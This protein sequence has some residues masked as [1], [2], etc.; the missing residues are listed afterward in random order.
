[1]IRSADYCESVKSAKSYSSIFVESS[2]KKLLHLYP[3]CLFSSVKLAQLVKLFRDN[4]FLPFVKHYCDIDA[5]RVVLH[6]PNILRQ[7]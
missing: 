2:E 4:S 3:K 7:Q 5:L 1:M 6:S